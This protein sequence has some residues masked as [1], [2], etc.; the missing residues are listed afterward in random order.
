[1][2]FPNLSYSPWVIPAAAVIYGLIH[3]LMAATGFKQLVING[4]G[5]VAKRYYRLFYSISSAILLLPVL[6][7]PLLIPDKTY[8]TI[9]A[10]YVYLTGGIQLL[11]AALLVYSLLQTGALQFIGLRQAL[12]L[13]A[14]DRLNTGG[15]YRYVRH[16]LYTFSLLFLWLTP[17]MTRNMLLLYAALSVYILVGAVLEERKLVENFGEAYQRYKENTPFIIPFLI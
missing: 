9:P 7:L 3:S 11:S 4:F 15:L 13:E 12:G 17:V 14:N 16:P 1:M 2:E 10:P 5:Q 6:A 8:Y